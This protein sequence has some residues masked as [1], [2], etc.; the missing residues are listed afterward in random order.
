LRVSQ[1]EEFDMN[2][3]EVLGETAIATPKAAT[4]DMKLEVVVIPV[5]DV[6]RAKRFYSGLGW[7]LDGDFVVGDGFR[8]IQ[9]TPPGSPASIHFGKGLTSAQPGSASGLYL[10][11]S[12]I[13]AARAELVDRGA[14]VSDVFHR[15]GPGKPRVSGP[16]PQRGSYASFATFSDPDGNEWLLQ[17]VTNRLPGR[18]DSNATSFASASD[19]ASAMRRASAAHGEHEKRTGQ[20]D[21]NWPDWYAEYMVAEQAGKE[22]PS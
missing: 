12:D 3:T 14:D 2:S 20:R 11:V 18:I 17:E 19:L 10:V 1:L 15:A 8:G 7:R 6:E 21:E 9:F 4:V 16:H 13:E 5:A 22:L